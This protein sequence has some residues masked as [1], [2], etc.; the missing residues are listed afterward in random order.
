MEFTIVCAVFGNC[1]D[2]SVGALAV[3]FHVRS[4][5]RP[6]MTDFFFIHVT[7][8]RRGWF[9]LLPKEFSYPFLYVA[10]VVKEISFLESERRFTY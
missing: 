1:G 8:R 7:W 10:D 2:T 3:D 4:E 9:L 6:R 5:G